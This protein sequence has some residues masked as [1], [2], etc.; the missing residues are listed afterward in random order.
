MIRKLSG[1]RARHVVHAAFDDADA[2]VLHGSGK[3]PS[4]VGAERIVGGKRA[5][6]AARGKEVAHLRGLEALLHPGAG[7]LELEAVLVDG[8]LAG[9]LPG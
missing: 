8:I 2:D 3:Q 1:E 5:M 9:E 7:A 6:Q 4:E